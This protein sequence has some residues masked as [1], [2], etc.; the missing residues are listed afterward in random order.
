MV[1]D[2]GEHIWSGY[3]VNALGKTSD[4]CTPHPEYLMLENTKDERMRHYR[5]LF[6]HAGEGEL[7]NEISSGVSKGM[8]I[9]HDRFKEEIEV[10][11]G[12]R[13]TPRKAGRPVGW[14]K[15]ESCL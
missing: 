9:G 8:A 10:L 12:R 15:K 2:P 11:T 4:L 6:S 7:L 1:D 3:Q 14:R 5:A 13:L